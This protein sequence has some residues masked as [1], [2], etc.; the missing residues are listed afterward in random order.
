MKVKSV[1]CCSKKGVVKGK[2]VT[3]IMFI[4][5]CKSTQSKEGAPSTFGFQRQERYSY[6]K[7]LEL[8]RAT[9]ARTR[10]IKIMTNTNANTSTDIT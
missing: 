6:S 2:Y 5:V 8:I 3:C 7:N 9:N 10:V 1:Y 4:L